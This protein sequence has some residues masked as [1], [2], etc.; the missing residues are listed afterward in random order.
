M[1]Y[2]PNLGLIL[3]EQGQAQP[4]VPHN[5]ALVAIDKALAGVLSIDMVAHGSDAKFLTGAE[6]TNAMLR[7]VNAASASWLVVQAKPKAWIV[8][9]DSAHPL[10]VQTAGQA[11]PPTLPAGTVRQLVCD[12]ANVRQVG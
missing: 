7:V 8:I 12:G 3:L 1:A 6:S 10:T 2:T 4:H 11:A 9:N 5:E